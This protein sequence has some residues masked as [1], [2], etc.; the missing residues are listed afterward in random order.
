MHELAL[1]EGILKNLVQIASGRRVEKLVLRI[2]EFRQIN[3]SLLISLLQNLSRGTVAE[4]MEVQVETVCGEIK[5]LDCGAEFSFN[6]VP[7][8]DSQKE[9]VHFFPSTLRAFGCPQCGSP[10]IEIRGGR[11]LEIKSV[12]VK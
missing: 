9:C 3:P 1:A 8:T 7:L 6:Q 12:V 5:C 4:G 10:R 2:G 11:E